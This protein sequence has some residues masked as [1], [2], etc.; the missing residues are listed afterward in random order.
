M[1]R[2]RKPSKNS[3]S[4]VANIFYNLLGTK[5]LP[6]YLVTWRNK[7]L[8]TS[9]VQ[10]LLVANPMGRNGVTRRNWTAAALAL[11]VLE[12]VAITLRNVCQYWKGDLDK[13]RNSVDT[14]AGYMMKCYGGNR[15]SCSS[16]PLARLACCTGSGRGKCWFTR[17]SNLLGQGIC[18]L[19]LSSKDYAFLLSVIQMKLCHEAIDFFSCRKNTSRCESINR[20]IAKSCP[21]NNPQDRVCSVVGRQNNSFQDFVHMKYRASHCPLPPHSIGYRII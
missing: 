13:I 4:V 15:R 16:A 11:D 21:S 9:F 20:A 10:T 17:S 14:V 5:I 12:R 8:I 7:F 1:P 6:M 19:N 3:T 18:C 2:V